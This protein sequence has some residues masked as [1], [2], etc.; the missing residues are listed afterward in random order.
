[1]ADR[2]RSLR[3]ERA[4]LVADLRHQ[5]KTWV[6]V[7]TTFAGR[8]RVNMR[9]AFRLAHGWSQRQAAEAWNARWPDEPKTFKNFSYW[10]VWPS[11]TGHAP[12]LETL[13][14]LAE[15]Y[16]CSV[17][18]LLTDYSDYRHL[19]PARQDALPAGTEAP[20]KTVPAHSATWPITLAAPATPPTGSAVIVSDRLV[21]DFEVLTDTYRRMDYRAGALSVQADVVSHLRRMLEVGNRASSGRTEHRLLRAIAD[22]AQLA[23]W[24]AVDG[25]NYALA[26]SYCQLALSVAEKNNDRAM[27]AYVLGIIGHIHLDAG[28][29]NKAL[30]VLSTAQELSEHGVPP[31]VRAW[32]TEALCEAHAFAGEPGTGLR[33]LHAA[34][35]GFDAVSL[36]NTPAWLSFFNADCHMARRQGR[37]LMLLGHP[38]E[39]TQALLEALNTLPTAFVRERSGTL[40]D[41]AFVYARQREIEE[42]CRVAA[43]AE[44]L[45]RSTQSEHNLRRLRELLV[46]LLPWTSMECVQDLCRRLLLNLSLMQTTSA[47]TAP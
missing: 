20:S 14:R 39:A 43:E 21:D 47:I 31:A 42:A 18:D 26:R 36:D 3:Q 44:T 1:M 13:S 24:L 38:R 41:L 25:Q 29:G 45:A 28:E 11:G 27:R 16:E 37:C 7:A 33:T 40:I 10:E 15:L 4:Q 12:S 30:R 2:T 8:Y 35:T 22:G 19:D 6:G 17:A 32:V 9:V 34:E 23:G 46:E 5:G